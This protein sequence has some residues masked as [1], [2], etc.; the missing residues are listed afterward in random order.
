MWGVI[1]LGPPLNI[2]PAVTVVKWVEKGVSGSGTWL[3][4]RIIWKTLTFLSAKTIYSS[5]VR[6]ESLGWD[7]GVHVPGYG[8]WS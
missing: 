4:V 3:H 2:N 5:L 6:P 8:L 1:G 7:P